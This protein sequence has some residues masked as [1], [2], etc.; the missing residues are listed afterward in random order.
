M[1][2]QAEGN[3]QSVKSLHIMQVKVHLARQKRQE[4]GEN[5][6]TNSKMG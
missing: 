2:H 5:D 3:G 4:K 6:A 1:S